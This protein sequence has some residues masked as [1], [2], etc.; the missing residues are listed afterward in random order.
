MHKLLCAGIALILSLVQI[1][2]SGNLNATDDP[3]ETG[4]VPAE[5]RALY[6]ELDAKL[7]QLDKTLNSHW[8]GK[9]SGVK[10]GVELLVANANR[11]EILLIESVFKATVL[12]LDRL[13][14]LGV[15]SVAVSIQFPMLTQS[16]PRF[17]EYKNFYQRVAR[18]IR[19]RDFIFIVETGTFFRESEFTKFEINYDNLTFDT[20]NAQLKEM[21]DIIIRDLGPDYLTIL[22]E[23]DTMQNNTGLKFSV[24]NFSTTIRH[25]VRGVDASGVKLGA[26]AG[27]W[28]HIEFFNAL[29]EI[30]Q[31]HYIDLH[32]YPVQHDFVW[33]KVSRIADLAAKHG[34]RV[35]FGEAWLYKVSKREFR[36]ISHVEAF[37]RDVYSFWQPL[38]SLFLEVLANL[39]HHVDAEFC[40]FFWMKHLY[41][42]L[43]YG[44]QTRKLR[45]QQLM[46]K[47][48]IIAGQNIIKNRLS[49]TG[50]TF[51][52]I[53]AGR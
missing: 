7:N 22:T 40:S 2:C 21:T 30:P 31:L 18:E 19:R 26:G 24:K 23:P 52:S 13:Q 49:K 41:A 46:N 3:S 51:R 20:F 14:E 4:R 39:S 45:A 43:D 35:S 1:S 9:T 36:R 11:G 42:Y 6:S 48:D 50:E 12:T 8:D 38:D 15:R 27:T 44:P 37:A 28:S 53:T 5:Y 34:K 25:I 17:D 10:F 32:V 47:M 29:A 33:D 16:F